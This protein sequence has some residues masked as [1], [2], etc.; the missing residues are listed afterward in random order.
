MELGRIRKFN[1]GLIVAAAVCAAVLS[2]T[3]ATARADVQLHRLFST[4][5]VL[6]Q[7]MRVPIFGTAAVGEA[8]SVRIQDQE[9]QTNA[10]AEGNWRIEVGPLKPGGPFVLTV[11][12]D[13]R[14]TVNNVFVGE[15]W[16]CAGGTNMQSP[17]INAD[18]YG[19]VMTNSA[20]QQLRL[21]MLKREGSVT[22]RT[23]TDV[24]WI[25]AG[26]ASVGGFSAV[27]YY[28]GR[29]IA[30]SQNVPVGLISCN[31]YLSSIESWISKPALEGSP[32][33]KK[34][35][36]KP[37]SHI[38]LKSPTV[39]FN[40][41]VNPITQYAVRG[42]LWY[43][44]EGSLEAAYQ[45]REALPLLIA[46][47]RKHWKQPNLPFLIVQLAPNK[48]P[49]KVM[50]ESKLAELRESQLLAAKQTPNTALIVITD[51]G[52]P[53]DI[54]PRQ[55]EPVG[56]RLALA[57]ESMVYGGKAEYRGP[58]FASANFSKG[59][60]LLRFQN[61]GGGLMAKGDELKGFFV[62][63]ADRVFYEGKAVIEGDGVVVTSTQV[64]N[65]EAAR[66][67]WADFPQGNLFSKEGLP[68]SPFR[69]DN[70]PLLTSPA[71]E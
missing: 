27:G 43:H 71:A 67:G 21:Y 10:D 49:I 52:D 25:Q 35:L 46:D 66:Y 48:V 16:V 57:A 3:A 23:T 9:G 20:N 47:W 54:H 58:M 4:G 39:I 53:Y 22:P 41:M 12:G 30:K 44:G 29:G 8:V 15:V 1:A 50:A 5:A 38:D 69:T 65:P 13:K 64:P 26:A 24:P 34:A 60:A 2:S 63:G 40:G 68:A 33:L 28:F 42:V 7:G 70:Y 59:Q 17:V 14:L 11:G 19:S 32:T 62:A 55:K 36:D 61:V 51:H 45:Y 18:G 56:Q 37:I 31:N 6:Q